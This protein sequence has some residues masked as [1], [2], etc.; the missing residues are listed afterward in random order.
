[1]IIAQ[2]TDLH[3]GFDPDNPTEFNRKRLDQV[4]ARLNALSPQPVCLIATG[5]LVDRG[6]KPSYQRLQNAL[7]GC[8]FPVWPCPGNHD[9]R[10]NFV[11]AF[12]QVELAD[13]FVQYA[14]DLGGLRLLVLDTLDE[15]RHGGGY[16]EKRVS[17][18]Q[19]QLAAQPD[20]PTLIAMHHPPVDIGIAWMTT[21]DDEPWVK[22]FKSAIAEAKNVVG[23]IA[24]HIHRSIT[25]GWER[26]TVR[27]C[28]STAPQVALHLGPI[29]SDAP[30]GRPMIIADPPGFALHHWNGRN[31][32]THFDTGDDHVVL[33]RYDAKMQGLVKALLAERPEDT[34]S[35]H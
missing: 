11:E 9:Q 30:D 17:W 3:L 33:A 4:L 6:D 1:M 8:R 27:V 20:T 15:G 13:G 24:G 10:A 5:D 34:L 25:I 31:L 29:D 28:P 23:I 14:V 2:I 7:G 26:T 18:L 19:A 12:P 32:T 21:N 22:Q 16:C 35:P